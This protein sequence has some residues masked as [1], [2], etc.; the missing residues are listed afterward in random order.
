M[1]LPGTEM[2]LVTF[3]FTLLE[4]AMFFVQLALFLIRPSD[5]HRRWYLVLLGLLIV[6]NITGGLFPDPA[7]DIPE[8]VQ[9]IIAYGTGFLAAAYFPYYFYRVFDLRL[10]RFHALFGV[11]LFLLLPFLLF[12]VI[13]YA[14]HKDIVLAVRYGV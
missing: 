3:V 13:D 11:P 10:L 5:R 8:H 6:Y 2:H 12:F 1:L 9:N 14:W 7:I 4:C